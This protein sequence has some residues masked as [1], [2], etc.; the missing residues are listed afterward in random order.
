M[1]YI[2]Y[3]QM[4]HLQSMNY[5]DFPLG[6]TRFV[7][8][9]FSPYYTPIR[10]SGFWKPIFLQ[11]TDY[12]LLNQAFYFTSPLGNRKNLLTSIQLEINY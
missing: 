2:G 10:L 5:T 6:I 3:T 9:S 1:F 4:S 8:N 11:V 12:S 7:R